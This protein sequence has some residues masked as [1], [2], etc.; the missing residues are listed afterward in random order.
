MG[1]NQG[2]AIT[3]SI[4]IFSDCLILSL[5]TEVLEIIFHLVLE[6]YNPTRW[7]FLDSLNLSGVSTRFRDIL[8]SGQFWPTLHAQDSRTVLNATL[9]K[10]PRDS[11]VIRVGAI[12]DA[13]GILTLLEL[14]IPHQRRWKALVYD[15]PHH[16]NLLSAALANPT[17]MLTSIELAGYSRQ[18][19]AAL[20]AGP[21]VSQ[22]KLSNAVLPW[23][24]PRLRDIRS[25]SLSY[26]AS[27]N[28]PNPRQLLGLLNES[29]QLTTLNVMVRDNIYAQDTWDYKFSEGEAVR[30]P[31]LASLTLGGRLHSHSLLPRLLCESC[32]AYYLSELVDTVM[33]DPHVGFYFLHTLRAVF[34]TLSAL[35]II[36]DER[37]ELRLKGTSSRDMILSGGRY[38]SPTLYFAVRPSESTLWEQFL[39]FIKSLTRADLYTR[40]T[41]DGSSWE[42]QESMPINELL[43]LATIAC[44]DSLRIW[45]K[46][47]TAFAEAFCP[48][49][50][51]LEL[52]ILD[53]LRLRCQRLHFLGLEDSL[54]E[55][56]GAVTPTFIRSVL[57][58][59][60][61]MH[62]SQTHPRRGQCLTICGCKALYEM[63]ALPEE[64]N[65]MLKWNIADHDSM[66]YEEWK[67]WLVRTTPGG[68]LDTMGDQ[69][70]DGDAYHDSLAI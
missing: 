7:G 26:Y 18:A 33:F 3:A 70:G 11:L 17:P 2:L 34:W 10:N 5:P 35:D 40:L 16:W 59:R 13:Q 58:Q 53:E 36:Y 19:I 23:T 4:S 62:S 45:G 27:S 48:L 32:S 25:L 20:G 44:V 50:P 24:S 6:T 51:S 66:I 8:T 39:D 30:L 65:G 42:T 61:P 69:L 15:S 37:A 46:R 63:L 21:M 67:E 38:I 28:A 1:P 22:V 29:P 52:H 55:P 43:N 56:E 9:T 60:R 49:V 64:Y 47:G 14:A 54:G 68:A 31:K 12:D 57:L 41:V